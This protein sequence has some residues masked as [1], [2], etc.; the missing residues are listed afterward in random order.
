M[1]GGNDSFDFLYFLKWYA[2]TLIIPVGLR[3][4]LS[5]A[6]SQTSHSL[7]DLHKCFTGKRNLQKFLCRGGTTGVASSAPK[8]E[9]CS[10]PGRRIAQVCL[11]PAVQDFFPSHFLDCWK[12]PLT[13][14]CRALDQLPSHCWVR[15]GLDAMTKH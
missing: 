13:S 14:Y 5:A 7:K 6:L 3:P 4:R 2:G 8:P 10:S 11:F 1:Q 15:T 12:H 9:L